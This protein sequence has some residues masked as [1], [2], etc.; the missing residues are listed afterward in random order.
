MFFYA[1]MQ[2]DLKGM[3]FNDLWIAEGEECRHAI[4]TIENN[5][6]QHL[7][8]VVAEQKVIVIGNLPNAVELDRTAMGRL[9]MHEHLLFTEV[10]TLEEGFTEDV[11]AYLQPLRDRNQAESC[12]LYLIR[13]AWDQSARS[14]DHSWE[15]ISNELKSFQGGKVLG[16]YR[17]VGQQR[18]LVIV[19]FETVTD[20]NRFTNISCLQLSSVERVWALRDYH[21]FAEDVWK[22]FRV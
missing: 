15:T 5:M 10:L 17:A 1:E 18:A 16:L 19:D 22:Y 12:L 3:S 6:V 7:Y 20:I 9:P 13:L 11:Q 8:K 4:V 21:I 2:W 14:L